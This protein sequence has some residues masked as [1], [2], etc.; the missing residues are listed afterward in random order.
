MSLTIKTAV[1]RTASIS[2]C[3]VLAGAGAASNADSRHSAPI[4]YGGNASASAVQVASVSASASQRQRLPSDF[5]AYPDEALPF[6]TA[7]KPQKARR[8]F[9]STGGY[10]LPVVDPVEYTDYVKVGGEYKINGIRYT[11]DDNPHYDEIG[12]GSW[13]GPGFHGNLTANGETYNMDDYTAAHPTLPL[14]SF[15]EVTN[16]DNGKA[17]VVRVNDR[18]P[19]A[20]NRII[21]LSR[22]AAS[23]ISMIGPGSANVRVRYLGPAPRDIEAPVLAEQRPALQ[24][25]EY[26]P[27]PN[28]TPQ[29]VLASLPDHFVQMG[30][31]RD[32]QNAELLQ[33]RLRSVEPSADVVFA[34]VNGSK[35]YRVMVGPF[36]SKQDASV[37]KAEMSRYGYDGLVV[38]NP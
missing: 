34:R 1:I 21:D 2:L 36:A 9:A 20:K 7:V 8:Q 25:T 11:P 12:V 5:F 28:P 6:E 22:A 32:K 38:S 37:K 19:F 14:P 4:R 10:E 33:S 27:A 35:Y 15:V 23:K 31:F 16:L 18:G 26:R 3:A 24:Q 13:Y 17:I 30:S 29:T